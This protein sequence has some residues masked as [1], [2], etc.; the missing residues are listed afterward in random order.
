MDCQMPVMDGFEATRIIRENEQERGERR[1]PIIALSGNVI[2][3]DDE[4]LTD[5]GMDDFLGK[6]YTLD[7]LQDVIEKWRESP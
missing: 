2:G 4:S 3:I 5:F 1:I 6:P 7:Q